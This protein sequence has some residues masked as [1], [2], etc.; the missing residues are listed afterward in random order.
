MRAEDVRRAL[1]RH[2][3]HRYA[4][5]YEVSTEAEGVAAYRAG[6][7][8][9]VASGATSALP[10]YPVAFTRRIDALLV[11]PSER[12]A[13][14]IKV[15]RSDFLADV[16]S[17]E[18][19]APWRALAHRHAFACPEGLIRPDEVPDGSGLLYVTPGRTRENGW[20][21]A[22][23]ARRAP[24]GNRP[25]DLP[26]RTLLT[27]LRRCSYLEARARGYEGVAAE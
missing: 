22:Y 18:K 19:Q 17:P 2:Y 8:E 4:V 10:P 9:Y 3:A 5:L 15:S 21:L 6:V 23:W 1:Y 20:R 12:I 25:I 11:S 7:D 27:L 26:P 24:K 13:I 14:E 16:R